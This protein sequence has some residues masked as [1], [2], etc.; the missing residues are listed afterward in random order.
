MGGTRR[1]GSSV[2][3]FADDGEVLI[4]HE[5]KA[6]SRRASPF[7]WQRDCRSCLW[8]SHKSSA[9]EMSPTRT[10]DATATPQTHAESTWATRRSLDRLTTNGRRRG[11]MR[12]PRLIAIPT[13]VERGPIGSS[14]AADVVPMHRMQRVEPSGASVVR[15]GRE[16]PT[17]AGGARIDVQAT[18]PEQ[19]EGRFGG[20]TRR[21]IALQE[22]RSR[23]LFVDETHGRACDAQLAAA[24][25]RTSVDARGRCGRRARD[26]AHGQ[27]CRT[28]S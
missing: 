13:I 28:R 2:I 16:R 25:V 22:R 6:G 20:R 10:A 7:A 1:W 4:A 24:D 18:A 5:P 15:P 17:R 8:L 14:C 23:L 3:V 9:L 19:V 26:R 11:L 21:R 27:R 12:Q